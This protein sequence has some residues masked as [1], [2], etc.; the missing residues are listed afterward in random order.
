[1]MRRE[2]IG[3]IIGHR[4]DKLELEHVKSRVTIV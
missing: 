4:R 2:K 3:Q 1:M